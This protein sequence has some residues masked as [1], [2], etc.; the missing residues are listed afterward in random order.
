MNIPGI[1]SIEFIEATKTS[2][3]F[4]SD[5]NVAIS[6]VLK[7]GAQW[8]KLNALQGT[9]ALSSSERESNAGNYFQVSVNGFCSGISII[10]RL[11][12][13]KLSGRRF[14]F[15]LTDVNGV[16]YLVGTNEF[17]PQFVYTTSNDSAPTGKRGYSFSITLR[18]THDVLFAA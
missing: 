1:A 3:P 4:I 2:Y 9:V 12:L 5:P 17:R 11:V 7:D 14:L 6:P 16:K 10:N 8:E 18:S 15:R 13:T